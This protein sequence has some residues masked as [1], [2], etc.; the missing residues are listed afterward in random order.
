LVQQAGEEIRSVSQVSWRKVILTAF[1]AFMIIPVI[2]TAL[3]SV[4]VRWDRTI[5]PEGFTFAWWAKVTSRS[6]FQR[7][8]TNSALVS[9]AT[10]ALSGVLM[11]PT[12][13]WAHLRIPRSK[14][15]IELMAIVPF[16]LPGVILAL[17]LIRVYSKVPLPLINTPNILVASYV[18]LTLPF[19]YR[20]I[21]N[22]LEAINARTLTEAAQSLGVG[23]IRT[24]VFVIVPN[25]AAGVVNGALLVFSTVLAEFTLA[26]L[27]VGTRFK[28]F[29]IYLVEFTRFDA[30]Q[31]SA[32]AVISFAFAWIVSLAILWLAGRN[33]RPREFIGVR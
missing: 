15:W 23:P 32:L 13:Y 14:P 8:L 5:W 3:F 28:T 29:P 11:I 9:L 17:G 25:I 12:A 19:M 31:A 20:S 7:T 22:S 4:S 30:R 21:M 26:N 33:G 16:G 18:V 6:A 10:V 27:L 1:V 2:A 24:L